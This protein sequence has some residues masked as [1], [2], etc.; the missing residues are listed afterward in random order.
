MIM[1]K[2][3]VLADTQLFN[4]DAGTTNV[5]DLGATQNLGDGEPL[6]LC[7]VTDIAAD[8]TT[9]DETYA[10]DLQ[11]D[12]N[13][14]FGSPTSV[15]KTTFPASQ[16]VPGR[17]LTMPLPYG[18]NFERYLRAFLDVGGTTPSVTLTI[19][20]QPVTMIDKMRYYPDAFNII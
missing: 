15:L 8:F 18:A 1:D 4:A 14:A 3:L 5:Y 17:I 20:L 12:D 10:I 13:A 6:A 2:E 9:T 16:L 7:I 19:F 11:T